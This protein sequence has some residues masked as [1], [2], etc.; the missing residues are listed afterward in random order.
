MVIYN[1]I[2][3]AGK[4]MIFWKMYSFI[5]VNFILPEIFSVKNAI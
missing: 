1:I 2:G 3:H 5:L 4:I